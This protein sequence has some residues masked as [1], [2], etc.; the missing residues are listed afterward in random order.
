MAAKKKTATGIDARLT[1][2]RQDFEALQ[3]D[4]KGLAGDVSVVASERAQLPMRSA[5]PATAHLFIVNPFSGAALGN[6]FSTHP[7]LEER[8]ARLLGARSQLA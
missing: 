1:Q 8:I 6:L 2:L 3:D 4:I 7:P 5:D